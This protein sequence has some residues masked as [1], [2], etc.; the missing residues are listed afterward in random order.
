MI[1][2]AEAQRLGAIERVV[3]RE[4]L[5]DTAMDIANRI[6]ANAPLAVAASRQIINDCSDWPAA[7]RW[8]RQREVLEQII[9]SGDARE[10][11]RAFAERRPPRWTGQ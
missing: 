7:Q 8:P 6:A 5:R 4:Q 10:G 1:A 9:A 11:A 2:A 3:P